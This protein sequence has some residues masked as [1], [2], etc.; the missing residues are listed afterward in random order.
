MTKQMRLVVSYDSDIY[1]ICQS[2]RKDLAKAAFD[3]ST[4][5]RQN[6]SGYCTK[7]QTTIL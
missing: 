3:M 6:K 7:H 4:P 2:E 1:Y 5:S